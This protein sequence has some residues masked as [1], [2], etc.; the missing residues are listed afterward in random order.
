[1][2][3]N[4][5]ALGML[6]GAV[7]YVMYFPS[8]SIAVERGDALWFGLLAVLIATIAVTTGEAGYRIDAFA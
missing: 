3:P 2:N 8:D 4:A 7:V 5:I 6:S 1:M